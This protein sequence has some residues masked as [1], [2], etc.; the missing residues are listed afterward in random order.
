M[1]FTFPQFIRLANNGAF[2]ETQV[3]RGKDNN[4]TATIDS[5]KVLQQDNKQQQQQQR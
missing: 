3:R 5:S 4:K 1:G 2:S